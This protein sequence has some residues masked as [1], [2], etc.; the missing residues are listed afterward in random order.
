MD[1][2]KKKYIQAYR[3]VKNMGMFFSKFGCTTVIVYT[4]KEPVSPFRSHP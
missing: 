4:S 2:E 3:T 1:N